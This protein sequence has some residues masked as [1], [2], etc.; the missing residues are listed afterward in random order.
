M[1]DDHSTLQAAGDAS[2]GDRPTD[3]LLASML[4]LLRGHGIRLLLLSL[5]VS[6]LSA[7][8]GTSDFLVL[9]AMDRLGRLIGG[10][11]QPMLAYYVAVEFLTLVC[12]LLFIM[13]LVYGYWYIVQGALEGR[14]A[15]LRALFIAFKNPRVFINLVLA[16]TVAT[17]LFQWVHFASYIPW[18][19]EWS[20]AT[21]LIAQDSLLMKCL[22]EFSRLPWSPQELGHWIRVLV[23]VPL[24]WAGIEVLVRGLS[25]TRALLSSIRLSFRNPG[26][27]LLACV[28]TVLLK[29]GSRLI[30]S[31][32]W[33]QQA[34]QGQPGLLAWTL[35]FLVTLTG[36]AVCLMLEAI[37]LVVLYR[38]MLRRETPPSFD[39]SEGRGN[40][41]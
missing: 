32:A 27:L 14:R 1:S 12:W 13:P 3:G 2:K 24:S 6:I 29:L 18:P 38:A 9:V 15:G 26:L 19:F 34:P 30:Y 23:L 41:A 31:A 21:P 10:P 28:T 25:W 8:P 40:I 17:S 36:D 20:S 5:L 39:W 37:V 22:G 11:S 33:P 4:A 16:L 7:V 35:Y